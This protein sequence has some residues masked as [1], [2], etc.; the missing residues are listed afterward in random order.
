MVKPYITIKV[1]REDL[2]FIV[3]EAKLHIPRKGIK[4]LNIFKTC[5]VLNNADGS[6][7]Q[8]RRDNEYKIDNPEI[9]KQLVGKK[10]SRKSKYVGAA[11]FVM[12]LVTTASIASNSFVFTSTPI[13][14]AKDYKQLEK[15]QINNELII[16]NLTRKQD[17]AMASA[18][19]VVEP[20]L[21]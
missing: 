16:D 17:Y 1:D 13:L 3:T 19:E 18:V 21:D 6:I 12:A 11:S 4:N 15:P 5:E 20:D 2:E 10:I 7:Y 14:K 9:L 8:K